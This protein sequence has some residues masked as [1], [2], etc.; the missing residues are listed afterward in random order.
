MIN[1]DRSQAEVE[2]EEVLLFIRAIPDFQKFN[3]IDPIQASSQ[4]FSLI[5]DLMALN[6][7]EEMSALK[8]IK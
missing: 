7:G 4:Q 1:D 6:Y 3:R 5:S 2:A 8:N